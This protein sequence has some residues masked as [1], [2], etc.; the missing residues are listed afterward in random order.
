[1]SAKIRS[2]NRS[3]RIK[4]KDL[5]KIDKIL[6]RKLSKK[7]SRKLSRKI[8]RIS[9]KK[10]EKKRSRKISKKM[11]L[12]ATALAGL[13]YLN[14]R[15]GSKLINK[16]KYDYQEFADIDV[17]KDIK[18][19]TE[20]ITKGVGDKFKSHS[21]N[22]YI[23]KLV[24]NGIEK[25]KIINMIGDDIYYIC[26]NYNDIIL[27]LIKKLKDNTI[28]PTNFNLDNIIDESIIKIPKNI[29]KRSFLIYA[30][31]NYYNNTKLSDYKLSSDIITYSSNNN[32]IAMGHCFNANNLYNFYKCEFTNNLTNI[33]SY[34]FG[35][36]SNFD[37]KQINDQ[38]FNDNY[39]V[40]KIVNKFKN[41]LANL[42]G[43]DKKENKAKIIWLSLLSPTN[44]EENSIIDEIKEYIPLKSEDCIFI[45]VP[46][47][48]VG[49]S[50]NYEKLQSNYENLQS[51]YGFDIDISTPKK[52]FITLVNIAIKYKYKYN[53]THIL[54]Y[55][56][57]K[58]KDRV[59]ICDAIIRSTLTY[60][61]TIY[62]NQYDY[63]KTLSDDEYEII[64]RNTRYYMLYSYII[65]FYSEGIPGIKMYDI[66]V[67]K[68]I[69]E[70]AEQLY[71]Y[72]SEKL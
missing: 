38:I 59:S 3:N 23:E 65:S 39:I 17:N 19:N 37:F 67:A 13:G 62:E 9:K 56:S 57:K 14:T 71:M 72:L 46:L 20:K 68:Y 28:T 58:G 6:S 18:H 15:P 61:K 51:K 60:M 5:Y 10:I 70:D 44:K 27:E 42:L 43:Y 50:S 16:L 64:R 1:M 11:L 49:K 21:S 7:L 40:G 22:E 4:T 26:K 31:T 53:G 69:F 47:L 25:N 24:E 48:E 30:R 55:Q 45:N 8:K 34:R 52:T 12:T 66:P 2:N 35:I 29:D 54:C 33:V 32:N 36:N 63:I 41:G